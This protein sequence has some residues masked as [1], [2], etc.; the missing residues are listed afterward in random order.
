LAASLSEQA[1]TIALKKVVQETLNNLFYD[2]N[3]EDINLVQQRPRQAVL[4]PQQIQA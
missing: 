1:E 4:C 3:N 2:N